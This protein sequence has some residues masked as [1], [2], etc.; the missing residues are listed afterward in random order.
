ME[1]KIFFLSE[2][3]ENDLNSITEESQN[4]YIKNAL[5]IN[6]LL[7]EEVTDDEDKT[8]EFGINGFI[9]HIL[10]NICITK[11]RKKH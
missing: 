7:N 9:T 10:S 2:F 5:L 3:I 8:I 4:P 11:N 1:S 6:E